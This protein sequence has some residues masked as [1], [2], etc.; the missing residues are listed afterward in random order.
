MTTSMI[1]VQNVSKIFTLH[2]T[3]HRTLKQRV[4]GLWDKRSRLTSEKIK[5]LDNI[6]FTLG[7]GE[8]LALLGHNGSGKSTLM[9][10][11][12]GIMLPT[13]GTV[14]VKGRIA[15]LIELGVGFHPELTGQENI[16][17]NASLYG[18]TNKDT[19]RIYS[20]VVKFSGLDK[21]IDTPVKHYSSG[22]YM[23]LGFSIAVH[24]RP[25]IL[26]ADEILAVGDSEFQQK[27]FERIRLMQADGMSLILVTH[28]DHQAQQFCSRYM[29]LDHGRVIAEGVFEDNQK[30]ANYA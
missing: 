4:V 17:L 10:L 19:R 23:R 3:P 12:A 13:T 16:Y 22:M 2:H 8:S 7:E 5:V 30:G 11:L 25:T 6:S 20:E 9:Q 26:L 24:V 29:R 27:C 1:D 14:A 18:L 21:F 28:N 15:P